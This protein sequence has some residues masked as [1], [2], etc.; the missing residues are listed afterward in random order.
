MI[1][2]QA[3][4]VVVVI[5]PHPDDEVLGCGGTIAR[6]SALGSRVHVVTM[7]RGQQPDF[8]AAAVQQV[9][10]EASAAHRR[11]GVHE[12][13]FLDL[14]AARLDTIGRAEVNACLAQVL[15][16]ILPDTLLVPFPGDLHHDHEIAFRAAMVWCRP[17]DEQAPARV[18]AYETLSETNWYAPPVTTAF[19]PNIF[20]D[21]SETIETKLAAFSCYGSQ[22]K[23]FPDERSLKA[24]RALAESRGATVYRPAAEAFT[25]IRAIL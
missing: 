2:L 13:H 8:D 12:S 20:V 5:A 6:L 17:R 24:I 3:M 19:I 1:D 18:W 23:S 21:I 22:E 14:P 15:D 25:L 9:M 10:S 11:M 16:G 4:Q 7:T